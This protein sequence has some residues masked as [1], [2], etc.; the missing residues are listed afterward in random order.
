MNSLAAFF[1]VM[2]LDEPTPRQRAAAWGIWFVS[3]IVVLGLIV[4]AVLGLWQ[5]MELAVAKLR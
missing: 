5:L 4:L 3:V 1:S 2:T